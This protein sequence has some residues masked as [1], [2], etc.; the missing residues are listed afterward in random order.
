MAPNRDNQ[1]PLNLYDQIGRSYDGTRRADPYICKRLQYHLDCKAGRSYL[2]IACG[3][4]NYTIAI[5]ADIDIHGID[6]SHHML[7]AA[8]AKSSSITWYLANV[9]SLPFREDAFA[10]IVCTLA[11]HHF[12]ALRPAFAEAFR[13]LRPGR[14]VLFTATP[15]QMS[16]YWL[17]EYFPQAMARSIQQMPALEVVVESLQ[18]AGF[19]LHCLETYEVSQQLQDLFLYSG[20]H[21]PEM[22]LDPCVRAGIS[23][24]AT[25]AD[26]IE[27]GLGCRR[28]RQD[29]D[30]GR[31]EE[32][33]RT[34]RHTGGDYLFIV[35]EKASPEAKYP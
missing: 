25:L 27:V 30:S 19:H 29:I 7:D 18:A 14:F 10:G 22:Y 13:V 34:Y 11:I 33:M 4:G 1:H 24:F 12:R 16:H 3:T 28:L 26:P 21:R 35:A 17:N 32:I 20:K 5:S 15:E 9:E 2:D 8:R 31:I 23:T 6:C